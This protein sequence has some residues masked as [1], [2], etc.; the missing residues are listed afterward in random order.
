[1]KYARKKK[2]NGLAVILAV[3]TVLLI[4]Q[5]GVVVY[6][7]NRTQ[8]KDGDGTASTTLPVVTD[9][10]TTTGEASS[11]TEPAESTG[12]TESVESTGE[13]ETTESTKETEPVVTTEA[14]E[15]AD[16]AELIELETPY[17]PLY[18]PGL[19]EDHLHINP[20]E[21]DGYRMEFGCRFEDG[22][23]YPLF[24]IS[25]GT[26]NGTALGTV[27]GADGKPVQ[28]YIQFYEADG[29]L[30]GDL[31]KTFHAMQEDANQLISLL[32]LTENQTTGQ[33]GEDILI[34][35]PFCNL[36]Y[37]G[38]WEKYL[39]VEHGGG[40]DYAVDFYTRF[41]ADVKIH[42]FRV[43]FSSNTETAMMVVKDGNGEPVGVSVE[44]SEIPGE[45]LTQD[46]LDVVY[47]MQDAMNELLDTLA[48]E[49][50]D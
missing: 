31:L 32:P 17:C 3:L 20:V 35:T 34:Q 13:T 15:P 44:M 42:L 50:S 25:F 30:E 7:M 14:T 27:T 49:S 5:I 2:K 9:A 6:L 4:L 38:Q 36:S 37:P 11:A 39:H 12:E 47:A 28:V 8:P 29:R 48:K 41:D 23:V 46:Q 40:K 1:M 21:E 18:F 24:D 45:G 22:T 19:W 16:N 26:P 43:K 33:P 10:S